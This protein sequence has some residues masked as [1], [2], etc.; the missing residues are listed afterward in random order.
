MRNPLAWRRSRSAF[1]NQGRVTSCP[2]VSLRGHDRD[3]LGGSPRLVRRAVGHLVHGPRGVG[4]VFRRNGGGANTRA[5]SARDGDSPSL[6]SRDRLEIDRPF[7]TVEAEPSG[8][9]VFDI[10]LGVSLAT[11]ETRR[12][13]MGSG[14][15][16]QLCRLRAD[17][18]SAFGPWPKLDYRA[19]AMAGT[20]PPILTC[21]RESNADPAPS[22]G[23]GMR[24]HSIPTTTRRA[25]APSTNAAVAVLSDPP[26]RGPTTRA[27]RRIVS[28]TLRRIRVRAPCDPI[29]KPQRRRF[30]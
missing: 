4:H 11:L 13:L 7:G 17:A 18:G 19:T 14:R 1:R 25:W 20:M 30:P 2:R 8:R 10:F 28:P 16:S 15:V 9:N 12:E 24:S 26:S 6:A 5:E 23:T 21:R 22:R 29:P 3:W 27:A